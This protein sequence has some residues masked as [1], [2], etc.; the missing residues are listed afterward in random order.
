MKDIYEMLLE[1]VQESDVPE[2]YQPVVRLIG[3]DNFLA[4]CRYAAGDEIYFPMQKSI[5]R[6][7]RKR[8]IVQEYDGYNMAELSQKY[9]LTQGMVKNI[10]KG[11]NTA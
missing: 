4:M 2:P 6:N 11:S 8:L 1:Y 9:N 7:T 10:V 3:L 5:L